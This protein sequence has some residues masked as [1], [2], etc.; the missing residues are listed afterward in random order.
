MKLT[1]YKRR[2]E[3]AL[4]DPFRMESMIE[5]MADDELFPVFPAFYPGSVEMK[6]DIKDR[7]KEY[8][9]DAELPGYKKDEVTVEYVNNLLTITAAK[10]EEHEVKGEN[11]I[12]Q[13]RK[14][15]TISRSFTVDNVDAHKISAKF[16]NGVLCL[17]LPKI[18]PTVETSTRIPIE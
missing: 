17:M 4:L 13:E 9:I 2:N 12:R 7:E 11:Y 10:H 1:P 18:T 3:L 8:E 5:R 14:F 6:V 16:D 15:G